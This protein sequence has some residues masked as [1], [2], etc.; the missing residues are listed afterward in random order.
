MLTF[1]TGQSNDKGAS[2][3]GSNQGGSPEV[4]QEAVGTSGLA[5]AVAALG[6]QEAVR[7]SGLVAALG[8]QEAVRTSGL[9]AAVAALG[10]QEAV[11]TSGLA[12]S[13]AAQGEI[14]ALGV[15]ALQGW[16]LDRE[17]LWGAAIGERMSGSALTGLSGVSAPLRDWSEALGRVVGP[18]KSPKARRKRTAGDFFAAFETQVDTLPELLRALAAMQAK[19]SRL[20]L[21]WRGQQNADWAVDSSLTRRLRRDGRELGEEEMIA[22]EEFQMVAADRW[23]IPHILGDLNFLAE[24]QH[25]GAPT[26]LVDV[27]VDPEVAV[28][29]AV[30]E[31]NEL[32][33]TDARVLAWGRSAA[34]KRNMPI[35]PPAVIPSAGGNAFWHQWTDKAA[36]RDK[37]WGTGAALRSWQPAA[38]NERMRAQRAAFLFDAEPIIGD[39]LL[40]MFNQ[41][42]DDDWTAGEIAEATRI[43]GFPSRHDRVAQPNPADIVPMFSL[44]IA[45]SAKRDVRAY[46]E[47]KGLTEETIYP[48]R[49]GLIS[50]LGRMSVGPVALN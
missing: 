6:V 28:W 12:A 1:M 29:F 15:S 5:A 24:L 27:S 42:L 8:A 48:D 18:N 33:G 50:F 43:V 31:S 41:Q 11:R 23:G 47:S 34:P 2:S 49:A 14:R 38:L 26:R 21:V 10:A 46:L 36:R 7:T 4:A 3:E 40:E 32:D 30:Q 37:D 13:V 25:E 45:A 35:Y 17:G 9:A 19:N 20:G 39:E 16:G 44:R 22:V